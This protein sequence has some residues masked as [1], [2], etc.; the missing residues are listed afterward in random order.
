MTGPEVTTELTLLH[1]RHGVPVA[2]RLAAALLALDGYSSIDPQCP[3]GGPDGLKDVICNRD[4]RRIVGAAFFPPTPQT[5]AQISSKFADDLE[6]V[7]RNGAAGIAFVTNQRI[8]PAQRQSL[9]ELAN[10]T[11]ATSDLFHL[12]RVR[13]LLDSPRGYGLRLQYL[14]IPMSLEDQTAFFAERD[15][16]LEGR[17]DRLERMLTTVAEH[18]GT[19]SVEP[20]GVTMAAAPSP[21]TRSLLSSMHLAAVPDERL[22][23]GRFR[24]V[25]NWLGARSRED[26]VYVPPPPEEVSRRVDSM[27]TDY[28]AR[29]MT[30]PP[31]T[32]LDRAIQHVAW[33]YVEFLSIHPFID[34]NGKV[35]RALLQYEL[36]R[37]CGAHVRT[38][39]LQTPEHFAALARAMHGDIA[40]VLDDLRHAAVL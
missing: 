29:L 19:P 32:S 36:G 34:G 1:W 38:G 25:Q 26:A 21:P 8:L 16:K 33:L 15:G 35:A 9:S 27:L 11:G 17:F 37:L 12:E 7:A 4:G 22:G 24:T 31:G 30:D 23:P 40:G 6:G 20:I 10:S 39:V 18:V 28:R 14:R 13:G 3:L 5:E 2:E